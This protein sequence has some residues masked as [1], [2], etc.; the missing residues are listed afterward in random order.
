M[1]KRL[2]GGRCKNN[3][4]HEDKVIQN[5]VDLNEK[6]G[7]LSERMDS[8]DKKFD[9]ILTILDRQGVILERLDQERVFTNQRIE[10]LETSV[11]QLQTQLRPA[12]A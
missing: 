10:R 9:Q 6:V 7:S 5:L 1:S 2:E 11:E 12:G 3:D 4:M 8:H